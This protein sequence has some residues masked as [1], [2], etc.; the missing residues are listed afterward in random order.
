MSAPRPPQ[1]VRRVSGSCLLRTLRQRFS[2]LPIAMLTLGCTTPQD[3][4]G[5]TSTPDAGVQPDAVLVPTADAAS[6]PEVIADANRPVDG[7]AITDGST[8]SDQAAPRGD[9]EPV[10]A[11]L[12]DL[13]C[14]AGNCGQAIEI[15][16]VGTPEL[17]WD[18]SVSSIYCAIPDSPVR[19]WKDHT[20]RAHALIAHADNYRL[21]SA[22]SDGRF[23]VSPLQTPR[24]VFLSIRNAAERQFENAIWLEGMWTDPND[25]RHLTAL[26]HHEWWHPQVGT[27][28]G[29]HGIGPVVHAWVNGVHHFTSTDGGE[30]FFPT[31]PK[32]KGALRM[33]IAPEPYGDKPLFPAGEVRYGFMVPS[34]IVFDGAHFYAAVEVVETVRGQRQ[35][36]PPLVPERLGFALIRTTNIRHTLEEGSWQIYDGRGWSTIAQTTRI[37]EPHIFTHDPEHRLPRT[38]L[39]FAEGEPVA[40]VHELVY[41]LTYNTIAKRWLLMGYS[42]YSDR[43]S[44]TTTASL[45]R[46]HFDP[47]RQVLGSRQLSLN[48]QFHPREATVNED[49]VSN[50]FASYPALIDPVSPGKVFMYTGAFPY[51]Y[52]VKHN[53]GVD[54]DIYRL[55]LQVTRL[56]H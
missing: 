49:K 8:V 35:G 39:R 27:H 48:G 56:A 47:V 20:G 45:A 15:Q 19:M 12:E 50:W 36:G 25:G 44:Y 31:K 17:V 53:Q 23:V 2:L 55:R 4:P 40:H 26:A 13:R 22:T 6:T 11:Q 38:L 33:V 7:G 54:R 32:I 14:W 28:N 41:S 37:G 3:H 5:E 42:A 52:Y 34:N 30:S 24:P 18:Y 21:S 9:S 51:L 46:P 1:L 10:A 43:L 16:T 29:C